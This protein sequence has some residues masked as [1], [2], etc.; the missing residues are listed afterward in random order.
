MPPDVLLAMGTL[1]GA[2]AL[3]VADDCGTIT[4]GKAADLAVIPLDTRIGKPDWTHVLDTDHAPSAVYVS[5]V[6]YRLSRS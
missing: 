5:G 1:Y 3:G 4:V 6:R 2:R